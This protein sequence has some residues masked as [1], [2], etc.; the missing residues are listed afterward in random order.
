ML[1]LSQVSDHATGNAS[2]DFF[3]FLW[4]GGGLN[5]LR[6]TW[7]FGAQQCNLGQTDDLL[8]LL[9]FFFPRAGVR[10]ILPQILC[11]ARLKRGKL[12]MATWYV[13]YSEE[14]EEITDANTH[15]DNW[16]WLHHLV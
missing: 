9:F 8:S 11:A 1:M 3:N 10:V 5:A 6:S 7:E 2:L 15:K 4:G 14:A 12:L 16:P 13:T